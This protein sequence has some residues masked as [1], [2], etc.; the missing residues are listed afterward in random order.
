M[1]T[2]KGKKRGQHNH[3]ARQQYTKKERTESKFVRFVSA[4][5]Q[6]ETRGRETHTKTSKGNK[7]AWLKVKKVVSNTK[8]CFYGYIQIKYKTVMNS[9]LK[10]HFLF[11][12]IG[13]LTMLWITFEFPESEK[14][15]SASNAC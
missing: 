6:I 2:V 5:L 11:T 4:I 14:I 9:T 10:L 15:P 12:V 1:R 7:A 3:V 13:T 8:H